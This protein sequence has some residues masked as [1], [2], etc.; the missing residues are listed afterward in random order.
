MIHHA[1]GKAWLI[2]HDL[3]RTKFFDSGIV[4]QVKDGTLRPNDLRDFVDGQLLAQT[5][6]PDGAAFLDAYYMTGYP[7]DYDS[8]FGTLPE[9]SVPDNPECQA[10]IDRRIDASFHRWVAAGRPK[11]GSPE[12]VWGPPKLSPSSAGDT[13]ADLT[14]AWVAA[15]MPQPKTSADLAANPE[16]AA[17]L[18]ATHTEM[19][20][21]YSGPSDLFEE[22]RLP[23]SINVVR[24]ERPQSHLDPELESAV[25]RA[26]GVPMDLE[27]FP[28]N[29]WGEATLNRAIRSLGMN[30]R[31]VVLVAGMGT[32]RAEPTIQ[33]M[34]LPGVNRDRL[35]PEFKRYL[36]NRVR[37]KWNDDVVDELPCRT[38]QVRFAGEAS[39]LV[40]FAIDGFVVYVAS[41]AGKAATDSMTLS[42]LLALRKP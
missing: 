15:G 8:E 9:Y 30:G 17:I 1:V 23:A 13:M 33:V 19:T 31:D 28:A 41:A 34:S 26:I 22:L 14:R 20:F 18:A 24:V 27:S 2:G 39:T 40:W 21:T 3:G 35:L 25:A 16:L 10:R 4:D 6:K 12:A 37:G 29:K 36:E 42:L 5:L 38:C 11:A 32:V 7:A